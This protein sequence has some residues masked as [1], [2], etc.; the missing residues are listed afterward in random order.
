MSGIFLNLIA[1]GEAPAP[2]KYEIWN[3]GKNN[4]G[5]LG[6]NDTANRSSPVQVGALQ[7]W[8]KLPQ[9]SYQ[10]GMSITS[11]GALWSWGYNTRGQLGLGDD[12]NRSSPV[13][14]GALK[15]WASISSGFGAESSVGIK[16][17][18]TMWVWGVNGS[19]QLGQGDTIWRSSPVQ[20]GALTNW[21]FAAFGSGMCAAIKTDGTLWTWG[22]NSN[23]RLGLGNTTYYSSPKQVGGLTNWK[24]I[25]PSNGNCFAVKTDGTMWSWG[26]NQVVGPLGLGNTTAYSSPKQIGGLTTWVKVSAKTT[27][28]FA[29]KTDGTVWGWGYNSGYAAGEL[30]LGNSTDYSSPVQVT[31][32][33]S[34]L[35]SHYRGGII[36]KT[37][38]TLFTWGKNNFGQLGDGSATAR[39]TPVAIGALTSWVDVSAGRQHCMALKNP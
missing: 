16:T 11:D 5:Q 18:G 32:G 4:L 7:T 20:V 14:V 2:I 21:A 1:A 33:V 26:D 17:D 39:S 15:T 38:G 12:V 31:T 27:G 10:H 35:S 30:G 23:G 13:Q 9:N 8:E 25:C 22:T 29:L 36:I 28:C 3:W 6:L 19:G 34:K 37:N 24:Q